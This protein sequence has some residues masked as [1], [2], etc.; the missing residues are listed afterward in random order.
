MVLGL[1]V[2]VTSSTFFS[3]ILRSEALVYKS[4]FFSEQLFY[5]NHSKL[6]SHTR[7]D[8]V[9]NRDKVCNEE[10]KGYHREPG[11]ELSLLE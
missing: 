3:R 4:Y 7:Q 11:S 8:G 1:L 9:D 10:H 6:D 2:C 5:G